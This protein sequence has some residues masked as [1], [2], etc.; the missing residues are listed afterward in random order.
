[1][2]MGGDAATAEADDDSNGEEREAQAQWDSRVRRK[3]TTR[4]ERMMS[5]RGVVDAVSCA[6]TMIAPLSELGPDTWA[7][8]GRVNEGETGQAEEAPART[9]T[10]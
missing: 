3:R 2:V 4:R 10:F 6:Q 9:V 7:R 5:H 8:P 1:M